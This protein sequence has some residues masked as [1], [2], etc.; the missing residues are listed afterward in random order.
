MR[1]KAAA[2]L[3][4]F[5]LSACGSG[6]SGEYGRVNDGGEWEGVMTFKDDQVEIDWGIAEMVGSYEAGDG[7]V[8]I[9]MNGVTMAYPIDKKG[10]IDGGMM[11][12]TI[13]KKR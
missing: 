13:C 5:A 12:G 11:Y 7:K 9:T 1:R 10:C 3:V 8:Y 6:L 2:V 4:V